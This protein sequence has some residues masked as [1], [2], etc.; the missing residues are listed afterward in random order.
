MVS[1]LGHLISEN[2]I[3][4]ITDNLLAIEKF[5]TPQNQKNKTTPGQN[6]FLFK[7]YFLC[8]S[9]AGTSAQFT[10]KKCKNVRFERSP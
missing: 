4:T 2:T 9:C 10:S 6:K 1:Y 8:G 3:K 5:P 7:I